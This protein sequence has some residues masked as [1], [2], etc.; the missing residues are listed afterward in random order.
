MF[1]RGAV[2]APLALALAVG[3]DGAELGW[4]DI[5]D[6][7]SEEGAAVVIDDDV[8]LGDVVLVVVVEVVTCWDIGCK[9]GGE[10]GDGGEA[11]S[12]PERASATAPAAPAVVETEVA[13]G[14]SGMPWAGLEDRGTLLLAGEAFSFRLL[15]D[16]ALLFHL[17][18][19]FPF[20]GLV[21]GDVVVDGTVDVA[22]VAATGGTKAADAAVVPAGTDLC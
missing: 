11:G 20:F 2:C 18:R 5:G 21:L 17:P 7:T 6:D 13:T 12:P 8:A 19:T 10:D 14:A 16:F 3:W 15:L 4:A 22:V 1:E 9:G